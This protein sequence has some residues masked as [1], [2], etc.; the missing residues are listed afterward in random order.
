MH[1][2]SY[3]AWMRD[4][5]NRKRPG[6]PL[7]ASYFAGHYRR[8]QQLFQ[9]LAD[10]SEIAGNPFTGS[11]LRPPAVPENPVP[12]LSDNQLAALL[13]PAREHPST[14]AATPPLSAF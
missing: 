1:V 8:V 4:R 7:S 2:E 11:S 6:Q 12:V 10:K 3:M 5:P 14:T 9:W 13:G